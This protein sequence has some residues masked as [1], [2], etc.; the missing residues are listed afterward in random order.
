MVELPSVA[1][2]DPNG[3]VPAPVVVEVA[4][5]FTAPPNRPPPPNEPNPDEALGGSVDAVV[6]VCDGAAVEVWVPC[7]ALAVLVADGA[8]PNDPKLP[9]PPKNDAPPVG[10]AGVLDPE[11]SGGLAAP[12]TL[13]PPAPNPP[14]PVDG[15]VDDAAAAGV[16]DMDAP[17]AGC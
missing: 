17:G 13:V 10:G 15:V 1:P 16:L 3:L 5:L 4:G 2:N 7:G 12:K 14:K 11:L 6:A 8:D 9:A